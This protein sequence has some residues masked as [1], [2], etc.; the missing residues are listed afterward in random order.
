MDPITFMIP[1]W[2]VVIPTR[3][4]ADRLL[5][6][7]RA[8]AAQ[9]YSRKQFEVIVVDDGG[10]HEIGPIEPELQ[11]QVE[12]RGFLLLTAA[13]AWRHLPA[14]RRTCSSRRTASLH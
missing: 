7:L 12:I 5:N 13:V 6:C 14:S 9:N 4:R 10:A 3:N 11:K 8:L 1:V 2:S